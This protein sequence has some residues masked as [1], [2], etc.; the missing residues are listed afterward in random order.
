MAKAIQIKC[1]N[2]DDHKK[3]GEGNLLAFLEGNSI[4]LYC[5]DRICKRWT[6]LEINFPGIKIDFSKAG[7][8]QRLMP[9]NYKFDYKKAVVII[10][11]GITNGNSSN[12][13]L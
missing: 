13:N 5:K 3:S 10:D 1:L 4:Y 12:K 6:K 7:F 2:Y 11:Q 8:V 9:K